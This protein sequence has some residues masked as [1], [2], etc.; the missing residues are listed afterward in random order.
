MHRDHQFQCCVHGCT[1]LANEHHIT[2]SITTHH[3]WEQ[4]QNTPQGTAMIQLK[5]RLDRAGISVTANLGAQNN[6]DNIRVNID[7]TELPLVTVEAGASEPAV[8]PQPG[9]H[10]GELETFKLSDTIHL[11]IL[12]DLVA[13]QYD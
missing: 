4:Q 7:V 1:A 3:A 10:D 11:P 8:A 5:R 13:F 12:N 2:C 6:L 9:I